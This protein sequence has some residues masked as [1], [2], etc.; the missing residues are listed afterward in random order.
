MVF[1]FPVITV[2]RTITIDPSSSI[3]IPFV[4]EALKCYSSVTNDV[5]NPNIQNST[6]LSVYEEDLA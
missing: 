4:V 5:N 2:M 6:Q 3:I 1:I